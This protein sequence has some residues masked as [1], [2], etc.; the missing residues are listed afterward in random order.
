MRVVLSKQAQTY[1]ILRQNSLA[2]S[3]FSSR[4]QLQSE[5]S[6]RKC[7]IYS[8]TN[9]PKNYHSPS[10]I[11]LFTVMFSFSLKVHCSCCWNKR[12]QLLAQSWIRALW[13]R[14]SSGLSSFIFLTET[15]IQVSDKREMSRNGRFWC[16][17]VQPSSRAAECRNKWF[18]L[19]YVSHKTLL[20]GS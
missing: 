6:C 5:S 8:I 15:E 13:N 14:L 4:R 1:Q 12:C 17:E 7:L 11:H 9:H 20:G 2:V 18:L 19:F 16:L 3:L 10:S